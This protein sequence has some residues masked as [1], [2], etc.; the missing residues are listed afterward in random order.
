MELISAIYLICFIVGVGFVFVS[1]LLSGAFGGGGDLGTDLGGYHGPMHFP[2]LSPITISFF[3]AAFGG[4]GIIVDRYFELPG[5]MQIPIALGAAVLF[6]GTIGMLYVKIVGALEGSTHVNTEEI[7]GREAEVTVGIPAKGV[8]QIS[9]IVGARYTA[10][11]RAAD[12]SEIPV[13]SVVK[14]VKIVASTVYVERVP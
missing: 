13:R 14:I 5:A 7:V 9:Y 1:F 8:G 4:T 2:L 3:L 12:D 11:A 10:P 6:A